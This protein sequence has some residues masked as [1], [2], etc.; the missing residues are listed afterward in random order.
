[1]SGANYTLRRPAAGE[2][3]SENLRPRAHGAADRLTTR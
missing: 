2:R 3:L 1:V